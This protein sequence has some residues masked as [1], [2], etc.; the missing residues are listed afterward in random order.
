MIS[1]SQ[2]IHGFENPIEIIMHYLLI[3]EMIYLGHPDDFLMLSA[4]VCIV[5]H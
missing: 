1:G 5:T 3:R 2:S 4:L